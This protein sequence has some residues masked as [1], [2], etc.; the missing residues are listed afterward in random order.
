M[1]EIHINDEEIEEVEKLLL[2]D[3]CHFPD[4]AK[5]SSVVGNHQMLLLVLEVVKLRYYLQN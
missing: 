2:P 5:K 1:S 3:F 4:D